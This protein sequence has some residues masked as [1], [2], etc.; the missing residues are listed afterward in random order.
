MEFAREV[1]SGRRR[2]TF[3]GVEINK[4]PNNPLPLP[5]ACLPAPALRLGETAAD[6]AKCRHRET[7]SP[8]PLHCFHLT[9]R[10]VTATDDRYP[11]N[12]KDTLISRLCAHALLDSTRGKARANHLIGSSGNTTTNWIRKRKT[13]YRAAWLLRIQQKMPKR[14][15]AIRP[16]AKAGRAINTSTWERLAGESHAWECQLPAETNLNPAKPVLY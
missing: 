7:P 3:L 14:A 12:W 11:P 16:G 2:Q 6:H 13:A 4:A 5:R 10:R 8:P 15:L 9:R 1:E